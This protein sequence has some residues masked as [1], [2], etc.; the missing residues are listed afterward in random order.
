MNNIVVNI[1]LDKITSHPRQE[2]VYNNDITQD[3]IESIRLRGVLQPITVTKGYLDENKN[4]VLDGD[5]STFICVSG[6][7]RIEGVRACG[8]ESIPAI[9]KEYSEPILMYMDFLISNKNRVKNDATILNEKYLF[10][11]IS[12]QIAKYKQKIG[13]KIDDQIDDKDLLTELGKT[14]KMTDDQVEAI[15]HFLKEFNLNI[16]DS[17]NK[18]FIMDKQGIT[19]EEQRWFNLSNE[20][21]I[22]K[23]SDKW[24]SLL[25]EQAAQ[26][27]LKCYYDLRK[28]HNDVVNGSNVKEFEDLISKY[29]RKFDK[30]NNSIKIAKSPKSKKEIK[31]TCYLSL[32]ISNNLNSEVEA[33]YFE[34]VINQKYKVISSFKI[35]KEM[36]DNG[37]ESTNWIEFI[38]KSIEELA[39]CDYYAACGDIKVRKTATNCRINDAVAVILNKKMIDIADYIEKKYE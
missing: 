20:D 37:D 32:P 9:I 21:F 33:E 11:Q 14:L 39:K 2:S 23:K 36:A 29:E 16:K 34:N 26:D 18:R 19:R 12:C 35:A 5:C 1:G 38:I 22:I 28:K 27:F 3:F 8:F 30:K 31:P 13:V 24:S 25:G 15:G 17:L 10:Y 6:H 4:V 7:R